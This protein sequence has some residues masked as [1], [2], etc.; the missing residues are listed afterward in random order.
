MI[1][2]LLNLSPLSSP[3]CSTLQAPGS[4]IVALKLTWQLRLVNPQA[5]TRWS[6]LELDPADHQP[7]VF[8]QLS[9]LHHPLY[10]LRTNLTQSLITSQ[11]ASKS[12]EI[13][14]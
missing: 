11:K 6:R 5:G 14:R 4:C 3:S 2:R 1:H 8:P 7:T 9:F 12:Y 13:P 10:Q